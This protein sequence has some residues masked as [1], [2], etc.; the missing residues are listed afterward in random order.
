MKMKNMTDKDLLYMGSSLLVTNVRVDD[1]VY[2]LIG[3]VSSD[4]ESSDE[5]LERYLTNSNCDISDLQGMAR[6][7]QT[8]W[9]NKNKTP[10]LQLSSGGFQIAVRSPR[11]SPR[12]PEGESS[13]DS[14]GSSMPSP[15]HSPRKRGAQKMGFTTTK[16]D[17][18][19]VSMRSKRN[20]KDAG[21]ED[22]PITGK[23]GCQPLPKKNLWK[24]LVPGK[25]VVTKEMVQEWN[26]SKTVHGWLKKT[27]Q[28]RNE[29]GRVL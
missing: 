21:D 6:T 3:E 17:S 28:K 24:K 29:Q 4:S 19:N 7:K 12:F 25:K 22:P 26:K 20:R 10:Q 2:E 23:S 11:H 15:K 9:K 13:Q 1:L 5:E 16:D 18:S 27:A 8:A 14:F